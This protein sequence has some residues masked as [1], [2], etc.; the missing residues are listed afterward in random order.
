ML[1]G[2]IIRIHSRKRE[3]F[4]TETEHKN[5]IHNIPPGLQNQQLKLIV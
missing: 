3:E 2:I 5:A 1:N 4:F